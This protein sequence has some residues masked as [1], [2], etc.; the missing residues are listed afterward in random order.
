M[1]VVLLEQ[2]YY[3]LHRKNL[4]DLPIVQMDSKPKI[5]GCPNVQIGV[6]EL[7]GAQLVALSFSPKFRSLMGINR[8]SA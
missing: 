8:S 1:N 3:C 4:V 2:W 6:G 5:R 7:V